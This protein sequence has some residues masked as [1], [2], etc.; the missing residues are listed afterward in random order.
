MPDVDQ[1]KDNDQSSVR[2]LIHRERAVELAGEGLRRSDIL[3][4]KT[5]D[6]K[7]LAEKV[8]NQVLL[9]REGTVNM[10]ASVAPGMRA[11]FNGKTTEIETRVFKTHNPYLPIPQ[12][13]IDANKAL[14]P[15]EGY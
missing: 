1:A 13:A 12:G 3:R 11:T 6:G 15:S 14:T 8:L 2:E 4:W 9:S 7:M 5:A 10:D